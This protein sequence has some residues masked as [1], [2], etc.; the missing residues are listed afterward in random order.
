MPSDDELRRRH[1]KGQISD[2]EYLAGIEKNC[3]HDPE[4]E[5]FGDEWI[6]GCNKCGATLDS[7]K[8]RDG[9]SGAVV[10]KGG[11]VVM[12]LLVLGLVLVG[13]YGLAQLVA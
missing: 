7:G 5:V 13:L 4:I 8:V 12:A 9:S 6:E 1:I 2:D 10:V 11:C 3:K